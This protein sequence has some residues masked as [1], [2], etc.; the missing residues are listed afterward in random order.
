MPKVRILDIILDIAIS[1]YVVT[2]YVM[3]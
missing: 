2:V 3:Q 1:R